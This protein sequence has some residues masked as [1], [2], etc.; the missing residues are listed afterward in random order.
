LDVL[1]DYPERQIY[2]FITEEFLY[3]EMDH[4]DIK[5]YMHHFCYEDFHPNYELEIRQRST[6]F[7]TQW[8]NRMIN[9]YSWQL[10]DPFVHP[11]SRELRKEDVL[12]KI[13]NVFAAFIKF[14]D[15]NYSIG[16]LTYEWDDM[17]QKGSAYVKGMVNFN[18][19]TEDGEVIPYDG[20]FEFYLSN[21]GA[22]WSIFY[23]VFPGFSWG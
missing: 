22:W 2:R 12:K 4:L 7:I 3:H 15:C 16:D 11:D 14:S 8:F 6:E 10:A 9:E 5:G 17:K 13:Q 20:P 1:G 19:H 18:A 23:L 21:S